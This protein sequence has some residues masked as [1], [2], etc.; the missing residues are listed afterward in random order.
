MM[1]I[2]SS[3]CSDREYSNAVVVCHKSAFVKSK[4]IPVMI[5]L[6]GERNGKLRG[7]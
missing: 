2:S 3:I 7:E 4:S 6:R 1:E 5:R